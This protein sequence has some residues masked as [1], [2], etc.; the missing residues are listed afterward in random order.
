M[1]SE[2]VIVVVSATAGVVEGGD[3]GIAIR[4]SVIANSGQTGGSD[5]GSDAASRAV[6]TKIIFSGEP[7]LSFTFEAPVGRER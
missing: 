6:S 7:D 1:T 2:A 5:E 4:K 3:E